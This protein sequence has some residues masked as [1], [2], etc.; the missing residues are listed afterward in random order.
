MHS[1]AKG[2]QTPQLEHSIGEGLAVAAVRWPDRDA[3]VSRHQ[4]IRLTWSELSR[5]ADAVAAG[6]IGLGLA[7]GDRVG[8]WAASCAEWVV[9]EY[10]C[11]GAQVVLV[12]INPAYRSHELRYVLRQSG[13]R[14]VF[15]RE[16]GE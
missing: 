13:M 6:L 14:G 9:L 16:R 10:G 5:Q 8:I 12:N 1:Y 11:S 7:P 15:L 4:N 3:L 2:P